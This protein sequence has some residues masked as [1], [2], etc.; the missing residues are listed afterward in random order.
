MARVHLVFLVWCHVI[1]ERTVRMGG[2][3]HHAWQQSDSPTASAAYLQRRPAGDTPSQ[4]ATIW[5]S[6][7]SCMRS[8]MEFCQVDRYFCCAQRCV[9]WPVHRLLLLVHPGLAARS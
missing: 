2:T 7:R 6:Y 1:A 8:L 3:R 5:G 9:M 4:A